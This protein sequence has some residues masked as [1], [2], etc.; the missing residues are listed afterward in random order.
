LEARKGEVEVQLTA[1]SQ[2]GPAAW[3]VERVRELG[4]EYTRIEQEL[5]DLLDAWAELA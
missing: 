2:E 1:A 4:L 3:A 5:D